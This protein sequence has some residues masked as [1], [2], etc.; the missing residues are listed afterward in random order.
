MHL[1]ETAHQDIKSRNIKNRPSKWASK[2][3]TIGIQYF[4][5]SVEEEIGSSYFAYK[6][7]RVAGIGGDLIDSGDQN[8]RHGRPDGFDGLSQ[9]G[10]G[11][12]G[13]HLIGEDKMED[14][15]DKQFHGL[16]A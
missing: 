10:A 5:D 11:H 13:H 14:P 1:S 4:G 15:A 7:V 9:F 6:T 3:M 16:F 8:E 12:T 2:D